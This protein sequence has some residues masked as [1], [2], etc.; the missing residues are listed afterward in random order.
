M[1][2]KTTDSRHH[3]QKKPLE[4]PPFF[5]EQAHWVVGSRSQAL[6]K[7]RLPPRILNRFGYDIGEEVM[8]L[9]YILY[10][11]ELRAESFAGVAEA[12]AIAGDY[13]RER[14]APECTELAITEKMVIINKI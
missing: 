11:F 3:A 10:E 5:M 6:E 8:R 2:V 14:R 12:C 1:R 9:R 7:S 4:V 13:A